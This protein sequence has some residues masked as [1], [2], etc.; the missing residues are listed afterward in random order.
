M[1]RLHERTHLLLKSMKQFVHSSYPVGLSMY[2]YLS[3]L[4]HWMKGNESQART[5]WK[6]GSVYGDKHGMALWSAICLHQLQ[7]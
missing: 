7:R 4:H 5:K 2:K 3:G 6:A 1:K